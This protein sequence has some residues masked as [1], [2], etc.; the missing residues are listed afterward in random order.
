MARGSPPD[1]H[2]GDRLEMGWH[3]EGG[4]GLAL[5][6]PDRGAALAVRLALDVGAAWG[7]R[8]LPRGRLRR[9]LGAHGA[10]GPTAAEAAG[11]STTTAMNNRDEQLAHAH[12]LRVSDAAGCE[13]TRTWRGAAR[14]GAAADGPSCAGD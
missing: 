9:V 13:A 2:C 7:G 14:T 8:R 11:T 6:P 4:L 10:S 5:G 12:H 1:S 3:D